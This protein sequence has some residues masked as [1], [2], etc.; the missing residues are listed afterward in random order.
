MNQADLNQEAWD[1]CFNGK[2]E[3]LEHVLYSPELKTHANIYYDDGLCFF[4][5]YEKNHMDIVNYLLYTVKYKFTEKIK[6]NYYQEI[7][8]PGRD[9]KIT[10]KDINNIIAKRDL[11]FQLN[12]LPDDKPNNSYK[13]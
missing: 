7:I 13:I 11:Y 3:Q 10:M 5:T 4:W 1:A 12:L 6:E 9:I 2:L 8:F